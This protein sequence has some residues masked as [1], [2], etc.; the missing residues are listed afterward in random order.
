MREYLLLSAI[1]AAVTYLCTPLAR[2]WALRAKAMAGVRDRDVHAQPTPR[3]GGVAM[4][5]GMLSAYVVA[6]Q[7]P[8]L[9]RIFDDGGEVRAI[10]IGAIL[11]TL[12]GMADDLW[13]IDALT[14]LAGQALAAS[15]VVVQGVQLLWLPINGV[16]ALPPVIGPLLTIAIIMVT[17]NAVNFVDGLDGLAAG[18]VA[19]AGL[20]LFG[21][22]YLLAV[23]YG[24][25]RAGTPT[26]ITAVL[27]GVCV[28][29]LPHN[30]NPARIFMG[31]SG[32]ML[33]GLLLS[34]AAVTLTGQM[35]GNAVRAENLVPT[36]LPLLL[37]FAVLAVPVFD[38]LLA[39][40]RRTAA[41]RS[42]FAPDKQHLHHRLLEIGHSHRRAAFI[43]YV[44]TALLALPVTAA[45]FWPWR[46][47]LVGS[48]VALVVAIVTTFRIS[49]STEVS[50]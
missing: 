5:A 1:V 38:L 35:D 50:A 45:A 23:V 42:P 2:A 17:I 46:W 29:F 37:P 44:W 14:K 12:L 26:F 28:G 48:A 19:I 39:I 6:G 10:L 36:L 13:E 34:S 41:G 11:I 31:D 49:A 20:S 7:F 3:W 33:L 18:I 27:I 25:S 40:V 21:F 47:V 24:F 30:V 16:I 4:L 43:M 9:K 15:I 32:S 8:L 22:S